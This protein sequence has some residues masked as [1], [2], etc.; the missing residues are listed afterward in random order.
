MT[1]TVLARDLRLLPVAAAAWGS[2]AISAAWP[3]V[4]GG[5]A[6]LAGAVC[7]AAI[8]C[9]AAGG[10]WRVRSGLAALV[11]VAAAFAALPACH[12]ALVQPARAAAAETVAAGWLEV[13]GVVTTKVEP[14]DGSI[15]FTLRTREIDAAGTGSLRVAVPVRVSAPESALESGRLDLGAEVR[16]AGA[17]RETSAGSAEPVIL[18]GR[19]VA[20]E[21][22]PPHVWGAVSALRDRFTALAETLPGTGGTL[23]PGLSVGD[24]RNV[25][26]ELDEAMKGT[27]L[28]HLTAVSGANCALVVGIAFG[29]CAAAGATRGVRIGVS[30]A[31]LGGFVALVTPEASVVRAA[32]MAAIAMLALLLGRTGAGAAVLSLAAAVIVASDPWLALSYGFV[33][34]AAATGALLL[35]AGPLARGLERWMPPPVALALA[36][37]LAAQLVCG[38][39]IVLFA[40]AV[41]LYGVLANLIAGPAAPIA[42]VLG[43]AACLLAAIPLLGPLLAWPAWLPSEWIAQTALVFARLPRARV[44][45]W[46]GAAGFAALALLGGC[47]AVVIIVRPERAGSPRNRAVRRPSA[48]RGRRVRGGP[49]RWSRAIAAVLLAATV[50]ALVGTTAVGGAIA[51]PL[52]APRDWAVAACDVGQGDAVLVRS[53]GEVALIDTGPDPDPLRSCLDRLGVREIALLVLTHFDAD[54]TGGVRAVA[55]DVEQV[56]HGPE[57]ERAPAVWRQL[58]DPPRREAAAGDRGALGAASWLVRWPSG[59]DGAFPPGNETSVVLEVAG[60]GVPRTLL[61]GD[62]SEQS[63]AA[64]LREAPLSGVY[65]VVKVAHHGSADQLD[66]LYEGT[67]ASVALVTVGENDYGHPRDEILRTVAAAG[68]TIARTD[69]DGLVLVSPRDDGLGVWRERGG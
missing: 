26:V 62:M 51:G 9:A 21:R 52:T 5:I 42:T 58:D 55:G 40:P 43:L 22:D 48:A 59:R 29:A 23:L 27:S 18:F 66:A 8:G 69:E 35:L 19:H 54:H 7:V 13:T 20:V 34:S 30:L 60:G 15:R 4:A 67:A 57:D 44:D 25:S 28:S 68:A 3:L 49:R 46:E 56:L 32:A 39:I 61:L 10:I 24:T 14:G 36:V 65:D 33:L 16:V 12:V 11:A 47:V 17:G 64:M 1:S 53:E 50:G 31:V 2:A 63:Q 6:L 45:W 37:P 41:P 38:P